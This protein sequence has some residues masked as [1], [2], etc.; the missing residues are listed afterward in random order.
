MC[1]PFVCLSLALACMMTFAG[2]AAGQKSRKS[3]SAAE[4]NGTFAMSFR[5]KYSKMTSE[6]KILALGGGK[7]RVAFDLLYPLTAGDGT[8]SANM[9]TAEGEAAITADIAV[10]ESNEFGPCKITIKF[11]RP[12][13]IKVTQD[14]SDADCGFGHNVTATGTYKKASSAKPK[15]GD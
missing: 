1:K 3:V 8:I 12:G 6:I 15:F 5:G 13:E 4:V 11:V 14:G 10:Y 2:G 9:G 7:L